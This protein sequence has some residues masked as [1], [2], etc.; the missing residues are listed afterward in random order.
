MISRDLEEAAVA[1]GGQLQAVG[2]AQ[3]KGIRVSA[4]GTDS[5]IPVRDGLFVAIKGERA[6]GHDF[7]EAAAA[8][9]FVAAVVD[10]AVAGA[11]LPLIVVPDT[12]AALGLLARRNIEKR[13][14][15][16]TPFT[17][18]GITGS[19]GKTT[20]KD[21]T[22]TLLASLA[23]TVAPVGSFNNESGLPLTALTVDEAR[24]TSSP[25]WA[26]TTWARSGRW[27]ASRRRTWAWS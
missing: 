9:G 12:V 14:A 23:P 27:R 22:K 20:T 26:R 7:L 17:L 24:G 13:R 15:L 10:H 19:V 3:A 4:A 11:P 1:A 2:P 8:H 6:D 25:R 5:R 21:L 18:V 16:G